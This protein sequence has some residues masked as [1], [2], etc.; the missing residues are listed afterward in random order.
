MLTTIKLYA[1][2]TVKIYKNNLKE[3]CPVRKS[4]IHICFVNIRELEPVL[5]TVRLGTSK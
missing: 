1:Y 3:N 2:Y 5:D 4:W